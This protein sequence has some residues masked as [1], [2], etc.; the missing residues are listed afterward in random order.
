MS[1]AVP[2][3]LRAGDEPGLRALLRAPTAEAA[4]AQRATRPRKNAS[5]P[6][7]SSKLVTSRPRLSRLPSMLTL[8]RS[9]HA[10]GPL[11]RP[12]APRSSSHWP[13]RTGTGTAPSRRP[14]SWPA[15]SP[16]PWTP[17]WYRGFRRTFPPSA[18][19]SRTKLRTPCPQTLTACKTVALRG[20]PW[21]P[22]IHSAHHLTVTMQT[23]HHYL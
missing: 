2:L 22:L 20:Q 9:P 23:G 3:V 17:R 8:R 18:G 13:G 1:V 15:R 21:S 16:G 7:L 4:F 14:R 5:H 12:P 10:S 6:A 11:G 19:P